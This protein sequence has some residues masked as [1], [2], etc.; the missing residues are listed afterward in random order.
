M[1]LCQQSV[2]LFYAS[3]AVELSAPLS[4]SRLSLH[5][6]CSVLPYAL[7]LTEIE[8]ML[9]S[10]MSLDGYTMRPTYNEHF[11]GGKSA[12]SNRLLVV[13]HHFKI[14]AHD[15]VLAWY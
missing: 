14:V 9:N 13:T 4:F 15:R 10:N 1:K 12:R 7:F 6:S 8:S 11:N 2:Q 5:R 3:A